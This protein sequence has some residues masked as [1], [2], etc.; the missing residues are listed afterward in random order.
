[1]DGL[2]ELHANGLARW[3]GAEG[4]RDP[5]ALESA[6]AQPQATWEG[7]YLHDDLFQMAAAYAYHIAEAQAFVDGNKRAGLLAAVVFLD[8]N[9][10]R[11]PEPEDALYLAMLDIS[12][13]KMSK[14]G[15]AM[16]LRELAGV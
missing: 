9:G 15:L 12:Q 7:E 8:M 10:F 4:V 14:T 5:G 13:R 3:G 16:L 2:L 11:I 6:I 1:L